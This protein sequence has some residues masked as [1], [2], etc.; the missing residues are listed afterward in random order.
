MPKGEI[1]ENKPTSEEVAGR[2]CVTIP[3]VRVFK[4]SQ[5]TRHLTAAK[6]LASRRRCGDGKADLSGRQCLHRSTDGQ[7]NCSSEE[8]RAPARAAKTI[9]KQRARCLGLRSSDGESGSPSS[10]VPGAHK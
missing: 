3:L 5:L 8:H 10:R 4:L 2:P 7:S 1:W 9:S 6:A